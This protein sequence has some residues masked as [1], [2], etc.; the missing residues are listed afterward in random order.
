MKCSRRQYK[1]DTWMWLTYHSFLSSSHID[2]ALIFRTSSLTSLYKNECATFVWHHILPRVEGKPTTKLEVGHCGLR[3][4]L[5][6]WQ[7]RHTF[8]PSIPLRS[9]VSFLPSISS[10]LLTRR[11]PHGSLSPSLTIILQRGDRAST[12]HHWSYSRQR[13]PSDAGWFP[14]AA[15]QDHVSF[16]TDY[17]ERNE[18][19]QIH[20]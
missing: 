12:S 3:G 5:R 20:L 16:G 11:V 18:H 4:A 14:T 17:Y 15:P 1:W 9:L 2:L 7:G 19:I 8:L 6:G 13:G 10:L